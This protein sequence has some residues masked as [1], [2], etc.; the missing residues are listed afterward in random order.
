MPKA[1]SGSSSGARS[2]LRRNQACRSCRKRKLKCDAARPHCGTCVKCW[3]SLISVP[4]PVGYAHPAEPQCVYD[5]VD[6]LTLS[7]ETDPIEKIR[8]L[9]E[10]VSKL[11][12]QL[13][14][15]NIPAHSPGPLMSRRHSYGLC[16]PGSTAT[17]SGSDSQLP[18][19][20]SKLSASSTGY[21]LSLNHLNF[22]QGGFGI[23]MQYTAV[24]DVHSELIHT[25]WNTDLPEPHVLDHYIETFFRCDPCGPRIL[26]RPSFLPAM[27]LHPRD[28]AFPHSAILHAICACASRW[29]SRNVAMQPDGSRKDE[30]A[31]YH[32]TK[33]R[34]Y[35]D[36]TMATGED[37]FQVVQACIILSWYFYQEGRWVE[38]WVFAGFQTRVAIPLRL[39]YP[40]TF[41]A[42][43]GALTAGYLPPP[44]DFRD[45]EIRRRTWWMSIVFDRIVAAGGW[46]HSIDERDI[47]TELPLRGEDFDAE[48]LIPNNPQDMCTEDFFTTHLPKYTDSFLLFIKAIMMFGRVTDYN[49]RSKLRNSTP[50]KKHQDPFASPGFKELDSLVHRKFLENLPHSHRFNIGVTDVAANGPLVDTDLYMVH[51]IPYAASITLHNSYLDL[52]DVRRLSTSRCIEAAQA[53]LSAYY[54]LSA[55]S[56]DTTRLHPFITIC[57]Y[58][59][60]VVQVQVCK[61]SIEMGDQVREAQVWREIN[62]LRLAMLNYGSRSP[63]GTRQEG[64]LRGLMKEVVRLSSQKQPLEVGLP[65][66]PFSHS[67]VFADPTLPR[68]DAPVAPL[69]NPSV[70]EHY[71]ATFYGS[72]VGVEPADQLLLPSVYVGT[73][74]IAGNLQADDPLQ[75]GDFLAWDKNSSR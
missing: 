75:S 52:N 9:E 24:N 48:H 63:I 16:T 37:I 4:A 12:I 65:L 8:L 27:C 2:A 54:M 30:F 35:I 22:R 60:A 61:Q 70:P 46:A 5:P 40:G 64:L 43:G 57:W 66:Y 58:L 33:T 6:G 72:A 47:G 34:K 56:L 42:H 15:Q 74:T 38:A 29:S 73:S 53:I 31:E 50:P 17:S 13:Q 55:T 11:K 41:C 7:P 39:N 49:V 1:T 19:P 67:T 18:V 69:P 3:Q 32:A 62:V 59:A 51:V 26:H 44:R 21:A 71:E 36:R 45:L 25:G 20:G 68:C 14:E 10:E 28:P 23:N